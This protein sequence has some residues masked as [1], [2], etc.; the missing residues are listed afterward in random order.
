MSSMPIFF[1]LSCITQL[2][3]CQLIFRQ[4]FF[5]N[6]KVHKGLWLIWGHEG[7]AQCILQY[8]QKE[9]HEIKAAFQG[10]FKIRWPSTELW[11][12]DMQTFYAIAMYPVLTINNRK[13]YNPWMPRD[14]SDFKSIIL[15]HCIIKIVTRKIRCFF[16]QSVTGL[17]DS[18]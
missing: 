14:K 11:C 1:F 7:Y 9:G 2:T 13:Y 17:A 15:E 4:I 3:Q 8:S 18:L 6:W 5:V 10:S 12:Q 16:K